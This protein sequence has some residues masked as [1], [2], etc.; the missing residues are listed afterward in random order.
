MNDVQRTQLDVRTQEVENTNLDAQRIDARIRSLLCAFSAVNHYAFRV[1]FQVKQSPMESLH[2]N[3]ASQR[4]LKARNHPSTYEVFAGRGVEPD[5]CR[6]HNE[7]KDRKRDT[8]G[9]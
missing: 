3:A 4:S 6:R 1:C 5:D 8:P 9:D 2:L 7:R